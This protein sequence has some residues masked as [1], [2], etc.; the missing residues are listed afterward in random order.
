MV[1]KEEWAALD[2]KLKAWLDWRGKKD[3][4]DAAREGR[5]AGKRIMEEARPDPESLRRPMD[6]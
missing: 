3:L 4:E 1:T 5:E 2:Q 6:I